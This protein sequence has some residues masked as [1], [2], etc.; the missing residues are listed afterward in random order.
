MKYLKDTEEIYLTLK[1]SKN[2]TINW[3]VDASFAVHPDMKSRTGA[4]M[5]MGAGAIVAVSRKQKLNTQSS[6]EAKLVGVNDVVTIVMWAKKFVEA[7]GY[8]VKENIVFQ[9]NKSTILLAKNERRSADRRSRA[10]NI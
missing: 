10:L 1:T 6:T 9:D 2:V 5:I 8:E 4:V 3:Y 7:Q